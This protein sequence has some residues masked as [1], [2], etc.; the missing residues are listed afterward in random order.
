MRLTLDPFPRPSPEEVGESSN[1]V[2]HARS[3][4]ALRDRLG[5]R[6]GKLR[7]D[8][9][10]FR[11]SGPSPVELVLLSEM[12]DYHYPR[13]FQRKVD[14]QDLDDADLPPV[15]GQP[16]RPSVADPSYRVCDAYWVM[17]VQWHGDVYERRGLGAI[18]K[19]A[20]DNSLPPGPVWKEVILG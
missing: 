12:S 17:L 13:P 4:Q 15:A 19:S 3:E 20:V 14:D 16:W 5:V 11:E 10:E 9:A 2:H 7:P 18:V 1:R 8:T 6:C